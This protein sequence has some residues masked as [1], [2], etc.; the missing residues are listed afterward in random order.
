MKSTI[1]MI[2]IAISISVA[3]SAQKINAD[4]VPATIKSTFAKEYAGATDVKW[5]KEKD[6]FE[7]S[8]KL[9][10]EELAVVFNS[11]GQVIETEKEI[12]LKE[13]PTAVQTAMKGKK[14]KEAAI[15]QKNGKTYYEA[16]VGKKDY[17]FDAQG[18]VV[19][20]I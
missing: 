2:A 5:D 3:A 14:I 6:D 16:E 8:F 9:K 11:K 1:T 19:E 10:G 20:N 7:A 13:L 18:K 12:P 17:L 15:I 4:K